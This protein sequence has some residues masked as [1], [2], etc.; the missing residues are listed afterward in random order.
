VA[1]VGGGYIGLEVAA[2]AAKLGCQVTVV[3]MAGRVMSRVV[4]QP[5]SDFYQAEHSKAGVTLTL[6]AMVAGFAGKGG[7][8]EQVMLTDGR[9]V[10]A[11]VAII[12]VGVDPNVAQAQ[13]AGLA[14]DNGILV[15]EFGTTTDPNIFAA[16]DCTNHP[17]PFV[18]GLVRLESVQNAIDQARHAALA[19]LGKKTP[20][21][22]VPWFWSDQYDLKL[23]IAGIRAG[24]DEMVMRGDPNTRQFAVFYLRG[25]LSNGQVVAV[26]AVNAV[27]EYIIGR[28][29]IAAR[30]RVPAVR[31]ADLSLPMKSFVA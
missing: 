18:G 8:L 10:P 25:G 16:G 6:N 11:D 7:L 26:E 13:A 24:Y 30:A 19:M 28:K 2:A 5:V 9:R 15:D 22:E 4:S 27:T 3:E 29:L 23:Q 1:L 14:C 12:G 31:L 21:G 17:N 20:Y